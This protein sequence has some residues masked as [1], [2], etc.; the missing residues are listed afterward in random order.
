M[1]PVKDLDA[2]AKAMIGL[3]FGRFT[4]IGCLDIWKHSRAKWIVRCDCGHYEIRSAKAI[5]N[6]VNAEDRCYE[7]RHFLHSRQR[8][9]RL[10]P[11]PISVYRLKKEIRSAAIYET[12]K[13]PSPSLSGN[14]PTVEAPRTWSGDPRNNVKAA[15]GATLADIW[16]EA[17]S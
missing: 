4:V 7:C 3:R 17:A 14:K 9:E 16:P 13:L 11:K 1:R 15:L 2:A 6:P 10:G 5:R 12:G 8:Y